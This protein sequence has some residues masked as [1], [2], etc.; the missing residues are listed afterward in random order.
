MDVKC[1]R[2]STEYE[3]DDALVSGRGTT[4][5]CTHCGHKFKIRRGAG[6]FSEDFWNVTTGDGRTLVFTS[7]RELQRAI[8]GYLVERTDRL[9]R[10]GLPPKAIGQIPEL[11]PFFDQ[12]DAARRGESGKST[13]TH[14]GLGPSAPPS[15]PS[16]SSGPPGSGRARQKTK[17]EFPAPPPEWTPSASEFNG[18]KSTLIGTGPVTDLPALPPALVPKPRPASGQPPPLEPN[19]SP[20][21]PAVSVPP[22][23][24]SA[25]PSSASSMKARAS[26]APS[27]P[28]KRPASAPPHHPVS[29]PPPVPAPRRSSEP[30]SQKPSEPAVRVAPPPAVRP[31]VRIEEVTPLPVIEMSAPLPSLSPRA[32]GTLPNELEDE[33]VDGRPSSYSDA[34]PSPRPR[35]RS[36]GAFVFGTVLVTCVVVLVVL[37]AQ[38]NLAGVPFGKPRPPVVATVDP[39]V[40]TFLAAGE[41]SLAA[42]NLELAKESFDKASALAEKE[43]RVLLGLARL[44]AVRADESWLKSR[45]L[46]PEATD[47]QRI[48][49]ASSSELAA[50]SR[51]AVDDLFTV[52]PDDPASLRVK[53]D[54]ARISGDRGGARAL[55]GKLTSLSSEPETAYVLGALDLAEPEPPWSTII[56]RLKVAAGAEPGPGRARAALVFALVRSGDAAGA[57]TELDRLAAMPRPH[58]LLPWLRS[59]SLAGRASTIR[60]AGVADASPSPDPRD[61]GKGAHRVGAGVVPVAGPLPSDARELVIQGER[62]RARGDYERARALYTAAAE[63]N[64]NDSEALAGLGAISYAQ[65]DLAGA[66]AAYKRVI[67]INPNYMPAVVGL[68]DVEWDAGDRAAAA[69][70]YK[71]IVDRYPEGAYPARVKQRSEGGG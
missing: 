40:A 4:V 55:L 13:K 8:Q 20:A 24:P 43:P 37:W 21:R 15:D 2:C 14:D 11:A 29:N 65:R 31:A 27:A 12:R 22:P 51:R 54:V 44:A 34:P 69:R 30:G 3:F 25:P 9:S 67:S 26:A 17:P 64:P 35:R 70:M 58:P 45:L 32:V 71:D 16:P 61:G 59:F 49:L 47:D 36:A 57:K 1:E 48:A 46:P 39:R 38:K 53:V 56:D 7:L 66:R 63:K 19:A 52:A 62:A 5:K 50:A 23:L 28:S 18:G 41:K 68:A 6:D 10:G 33:A 42:G 60:D